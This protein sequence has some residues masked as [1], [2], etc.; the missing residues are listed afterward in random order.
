MFMLR[1]KELIASHSSPST[2]FDDRFFNFSGKFF[3]RQDHHRGESGRASLGYSE[4]TRES[5][6]FPS[7]S[8]ER[9]KI[10]TISSVSA[11]SRSTSIVSATCAQAKKFSGS[12]HDQL[13][14]ASLFTVFYVSKIITTFFR[15]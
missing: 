14:N 7:A 8:V 3:Q 1:N 13:C 10:L 4:T 5:Q 6:N 9:K 15:N 12:V 11:S 2:N